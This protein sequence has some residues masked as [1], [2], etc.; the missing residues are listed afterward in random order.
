MGCARPVA[1]IAGVTIICRGFGSKS[2]VISYLL[3]S[4]SPAID[5]NNTSDWATQLVTAKKAG[6]AHDVPGHGLLIFYFSAAVSLCQ[7][8]WTRSSVLSGMLML[9]YC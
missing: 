1:N 6:P 7:F 9:F 2:G 3:D 8:S 4:N 5:T